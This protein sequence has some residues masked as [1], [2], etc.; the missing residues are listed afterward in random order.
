MI[1]G[2][3]STWLTGVRRAP[4]ATPGPRTTV[5]D[6]P[7]VFSGSDTSL[8]PLERGLAE[9]IVTDLSQA[10]SLKVVERA[11]LQAL[12]NEI[13][14]QQAAGVQTGTG[15]RAGKILQAGSLVGGQISQLGANQLNTSA[16]VTSVQTAQPL[17]SGFNGQSQLDQVFDVE[18]RIVRV[19]YLS[20]R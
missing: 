8:K 14:L 17:G 12:L 15:V 6:M 19:N 1:V 5:A 20:L 13:Q 2:A 9:L 3:R 10:R 4:P 11:Q 16:T 18:K 7:F